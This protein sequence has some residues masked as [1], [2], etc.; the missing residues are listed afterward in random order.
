ME[1][2]KVERIRDTITHKFYIYIYIYIYIPW[3]D[4]SQASSVKQ[5]LQHNQKSKKQKSQMHISPIY[6]Q[7]YQKAT[8]TLEDGAKRK[9]PHPNE[10]TK[11]I[12]SQVTSKCDWIL[13]QCW[14]P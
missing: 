8:N 7:I 3:R 10:R 2:I 1:W 6:L 5:R 11:S 9:L 12:L 4:F 14:P 13:K